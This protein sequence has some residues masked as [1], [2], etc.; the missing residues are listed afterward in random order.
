MIIKM[1]R[2]IRKTALPL[3]NVVEFATLPR[4]A[5][6]DMHQVLS[7]TQSNSLFQEL[8]NVCANLSDLLRLRKMHQ[9]ML[10]KVR[11]RAT[12]AYHQSDSSINTASKIIYAEHSKMASSPYAM[13]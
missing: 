10:A 13:F 12:A 6:C 11:R 5:C 4:K 3:V 8:L 1:F 2:L 9:T 7:Y